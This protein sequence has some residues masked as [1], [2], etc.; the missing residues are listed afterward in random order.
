M[1][2]QFLYTFPSHHSTFPIIQKNKKHQ[3]Q[4]IYIMIRYGSS[5]SSR[6]F[7]YE[8]MLVLY[9]FLYRISGVFCFVFFVFCFFNGECVVSYLVSC[10]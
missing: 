3:Y 6:C 5:L 10:K 8:Y 7:I 2:R 4:K 9:V 1:N